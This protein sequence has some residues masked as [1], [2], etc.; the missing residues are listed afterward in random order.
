ML[1]GLRQVRHRQIVRDRHGGPVDALA[2]MGFLVWARQP[3]RL[4]QQGSE[5]SRHVTAP[6]KIAELTMTGRAALDWLVALEATPHWEILR[7]RPYG[8]RDHRNAP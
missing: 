1:D 4:S 7:V 2:R 8:A 3:I 5:R 6:I